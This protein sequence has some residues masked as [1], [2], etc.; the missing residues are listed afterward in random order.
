MSKG[1]Q[2]REEK[3]LKKEVSKRRSVLFRSKT[4]FENN[5]F[6]GSSVQVWQETS[7][8]LC[9]NSAYSQICVQPDD[10]TGGDEVIDPIYAV[11]TNSR[12]VAAAIP[13]WR[14]SFKGCFYSIQ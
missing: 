11:L 13:I 3:H 5:Y 9:T 6:S 4:V 1:C 8:H 10:Q 7:K 12:D 14:H 2:S